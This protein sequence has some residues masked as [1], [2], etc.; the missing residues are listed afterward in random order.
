MRTATKLQKILHVARNT[1]Y[2]C[3]RSVFKIIWKANSQNNRFRMYNHLKRPTKHS[4]NLSLKGAAPHLPIRTRGQTQK[5]SDHLLVGSFV[6]AAFHRQSSQLNSWGARKKGQIVFT[7][8]TYKEHQCRKIVMMTFSKL[9]KAA[10]QANYGDWR[11][12]ITSCCSITL[13]I[14]KALMCCFF[15][16]SCK[17]RHLI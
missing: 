7:F 8:H 1:F 9:C 13:S 10:F 11:G 17:R 12:R 4:I 2:T 6:L 3:Y 16:W 5:I 14:S 15:P